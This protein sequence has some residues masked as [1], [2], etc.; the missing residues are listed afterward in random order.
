MRV[1]GHITSLLSS[2]VIGKTVGFVTT[3]YIARVLLPASFGLYAFAM[4][5]VAYGVALSAFGLADHGIIRVSADRGP[6]NTARVMSSVLLARIVLGTIGYIAIV[7]LGRLPAFSSVNDLLPI[8]GLLIFA[9]ALSLDWLFTAYE[10]FHPVAIASSIASVVYLVGAFALVEGPE[11]LS[12][13]AWLT[14]ARAIVTQGFLWFRLAT[15]RDRDTALLA[16]P[17]PVR[18]TLSAV[19]PLGLATVAS[20]VYLNGD[21]LLVSFFLAP[22]DVGLY[23]AT[24]RI[25]ALG[26]SVRL[27]LGRVL[28]P[29]AARLAGSDPSAL[30]RFLGLAGGLL[31]PVGA[32]IGILGMATG[33]WIIRLVFGSEYVSATQSFQIAIWVLAIEV[34]GMALPYAIAAVNSKR[35]MVLTWTLALSNVALNLLLIPALG[36]EGAALAYV[37]SASIAMA[38][39]SWIARGELR[40]FVVPSRTWPALAVSVVY[41][42]LVV[43]VAGTQIVVFIAG[44]AA[45][46]VLL[47]LL[48]LTPRD[49]GAEIRMLR[50]VAAH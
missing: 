35:Y 43:S 19:L 8:L 29:R 15:T 25:V 20:Q 2:E 41:A 13:L 46:A 50:E 10:R 40:T 17:D 3:A 24:L 47:A 1:L 16:R 32:L 23:A 42:G 49:V 27:L 14:V 30:G 37:L 11:S 48:R 44:V 38:L 9:Q 33:A 6:R 26:M 31:I 4:A 45:A 5:T 39:G 12:A 36:I 28:Y 22:E 7:S 21:V 34:A 18:R